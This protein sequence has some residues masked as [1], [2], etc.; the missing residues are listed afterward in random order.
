MQAVVRN[1]LAGELEQ[2]EPGIARGL[3]S[4]AAYWSARHG[5]LSGALEY[6]RAALDM[7][8]LIELIE[9]SVLP[10][11]ATA[12]PASVERLLILLDDPKILGQHPALA[13]I[14]ALAWGMT[15]RPDLAERWASAAERS[16]STRSA[17]RSLLHAVMQ[18]AGPDDMAAAAGDALARMPFDSTWRAPALLALGI[19]SSLGGA[20]H[21]AML[22][23]RQAADVAA[24]ADAPA[25][26]AAA[27]GCESL[28][29]AALGQWAVADARAHAGRRLV[30]E[31]EMQHE[32]M[33][34]FALAASARAALRAGDWARTRSELELSDTLLPRLTHAVGAFAVPLRI[35]FTRIHHALGEP[36]AAHRLLDEIDEIFRRQPRLDL[37]RDDAEELRSE[38]V[39]EEHGHAGHASPLTAAEL[40]LLPLLVT[41]R[42][43]REIAEQLYVSRNTVKTQAISVYRKLGV[44]SR[45]DA[46]GRAS[47]LGLVASDEKLR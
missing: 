30:D 46:I 1:V 3:Q 32:V 47:T 36:A 22:V 16:S 6:A 9:S 2:Q 20:E 37:C 39:A 28:A 24:A 41:H 14:G 45:A 17:W 26:E 35:T 8:Q 10:F 43:F 19:A 34:L 25:V 44:S 18:P 15:G 27:L 4:R 21:E 7:P 23:L 11:A 29:A 33:S 38:L 5:D 13:A 42:S 12:Q 31:R 40:R